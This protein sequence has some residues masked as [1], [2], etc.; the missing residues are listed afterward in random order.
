MKINN[1]NTTFS[2]DKPHR[3]GQQRLYGALGWGI[4][5]G[6]TGF[7]IDAA[8]AGQPSKNYLYAFYLGAFF[9]ILDA[10]VSWNI[11]VSTISKTISSIMGATNSHTGVPPKNHYFLLLILIK[12]KKFDLKNIF[13]YTGVQFPL[14]TV[15][16]LK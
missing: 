7:I 5:S 16:H 15:F 12:L 1:G 14:N 8:S 2:D 10:V 13:E 11:S 3:Y 6:V 9:M 4:L